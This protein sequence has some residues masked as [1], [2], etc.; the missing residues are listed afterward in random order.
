MRRLV[1]PLLFLLLA[2]Q[3]PLQ[4]L[5]QDT[6]P[7]A[8][9][10]QEAGQYF[11]IKSGYVPEDIKGVRQDL[12]A[13]LKEDKAV[14]IDVCGY[15]SLK[16]WDVHQQGRL[17]KL[18]KKHGPDGSGKMMIFWVNIDSCDLSVLRG[19]NPYLGM[20]DWTN[21]E[22]IP[23]PI[24]NSSTFHKAMDFRFIAVPRFYLVE[25]SG[26]CIDITQEILADD[27]EA[28]F[29]A[30]LARSVTRGKAPKALDI[31]GVKTLFPGEEGFFIP[32][33]RTVDP[34]KKPVWSVEGAEAKGDEMARITWSKPG[35]YKVTATVENASGKDA[36]SITVRVLE[37]ADKVSTLSPFPVN[38]TFDNSEIPKGWRIYDQDGDGLCWLPITKD[39]KGRIG[40]QTN[41]G[42]NGT[43][44]ALVSYTYYMEKFDWEYDD[45]YGYV[46]S[47]EDWL[48]SPAITI[49]SNATKSALKYLE[50]YFY[51]AENANK[52]DGYRL[53]LS[54]TG[55]APEDFTTVL[56]DIP[57][58]EK[59]T[60]TNKFL[61]QTI[62][63]TPYRGKTI[64]VAFVHPNKY[65]YKEAGS[66]VII[67]EITIES[68]GTAAPTAKVH[69]VKGGARG[70]GSSWEKASGDLQAAIDVAISGD[71]I[72]V[73]AGT[74]HPTRLIDPKR[75]RSFAFLL[76]DGISLYGGFEGTEKSPEERALKTVEAPIG[77]L[78]EHQTILSGKLDNKEETWTRAMDE[79]SSYRYTW[80]VEGNADNANHILYLK[81]TEKATEGIVIDGF[82]LTG[83]NANQWQVYAGG[84][85]LYAKGKLRLSRSIITR[86]ASR[87]PV[88]GKSFKGGAIALLGDSE[89][90]IVENC[91][92]ESNL[93]VAPNEPA[94]GGSLYLEGGVVRNCIFRGSVAHDEGGAAT[95]V[96]ARA[97]SCF[98]YDC[99][100]G[101]GGSIS[102]TNSIVEK[103]RFYASR[104]LKGGAIH[105]K[106]GLVHHSVAAGCYADAPEFGDT[107]GGQGGGFFLLA[108]AKA[109]GCL[110]YNSTAFT[111]GGVRLEDGE[112][113]LSTVQNCTARMGEGDAN[114]SSKE[115]TKVVNTIFAHEAAEKDFAAP[116][117]FKGFKDAAE[118][119]I[120]GL[121]TADWS[122]KAGSSYIA[123]G[124][125]PYGYEEAT[126][127]FGTPR[128]RGGKIDQG[129]VALKGVIEPS[130]ANITLTFTSIEK[131]VTI[132]TGGPAGTSFQLDK[133]DGILESYDGAK[134]IT[135][136][137]IA[138]TIKIYGNDIAILKVIK[139][140]L[141]AVDFGE[142]PKLY[143][144]QLGGNALKAISLSKLPA[145]KGLYLEQNQIAGILDLSAQTF[146]NV[147]SIYEN[148][149]SGKL[150]LSRF[151][152]LTKVEC[153][154]NALTELLL[155]STDKFV[156]L[157]C[158]ENQLKTLDLKG[159][160]ALEELNC[161][162]NALT[163]LDL[164]KNAKLVKLYCPENKLT[165]LV[166]S[167]NPEIKTFTAFNNKIANID[168]SANKKM[169]GLYIQ[170]NELK[171]IDLTPCT[172]LSYANVSN[173]HLTSLSLAGL[174]SLLM[175][176]AENNQLSALSLSDN[177]LINTLHLG[178]NNLTLL[179]VSK[180]TGLSWLI[181]SENKLAELDLACNPSIVWLECA[182]NTLTKL[183]LTKQ[184]SLQKLLVNHNK[185]TELDLAGKDNL[186][187]VRVENN[188]LTLE[189]LQKM[190]ID[191]PDVSAVK[192]HDNN[193]EWA[194]K[195]DISNNPGTKATDITP[196]QG[197][198]WEVTNKTA[199]L[200]PERGLPI[201]YYSTNTKSIVI[202]KDA[203][204]LVVYDALGGKVFEIS[205]PEREVSM[206]M[207]PAG[208]Y[209]ARVKVA[210]GQI[211]SVLFVKE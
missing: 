99:Y 143:S 61:E 191:L 5:A 159:L 77:S 24:I 125:I 39:L 185:L 131:E 102:A 206:A 116:T 108:G 76:K 161:G 4:L 195:L 8:S 86:N 148:K 72:W 62:D 149:I 122:L 110:V 41:E 141:E 43:T 80:K 169:E 30:Q 166:T 69:Y 97:D 59:Q 118:E 101:L 153:F 27:Y 204:H 164:S 135:F 200:S 85:A 113:I 26:W 109:I 29:E 91:L 112:L 36:K 132:G 51:K 211:E 201:C 127:L 182:K 123:S 73:A 23:Y 93:A 128:L 81:G 63:L 46:V 18:Y 14:L 22:S 42:L 202:T 70:D 90:T 181:C 130:T 198:G 193:R 178:K 170:N 189:A 16:G 162:G 96:N 13:Y 40:I 75:K 1:T 117:T 120:A 129:A 52:P 179:D 33:V 64:R 171:N 194:K 136:K 165:A 2:L 88:E 188:L 175:L 111:G 3:L 98:F 155:P 126:D 106:G 199:V 50:G 196:A 187:G 158:D 133:G 57:S 32:I 114:I 152:A 140:E 192:I 105:S 186:Q 173:N 67:D 137:P 107:S 87:N 19:E 89:E 205:A 121:K 115:G 134:N 6:L 60:E 183:D 176:S 84:S 157:D 66:G 177:P 139:Q 82:T 147:V 156:Q 150:D 208:S 55:V 138:K 100:A 172:K 9:I 25:P 154:K 74:Y 31:A 21:G 12:Q 53:L 167:A 95:L 174:A 92:F 145:L 160:T 146:I 184:K 68:D 151:T 7:G 58:L 11:R 28:K 20:G 210:I 79:G 163:E 207:L 78:L 65:S 15:W 48:I 203:V 142:N 17:E 54:E 83:G 94:T 124:V 180:Q 209:V 47:P 104:S 38:Y 35:E 190:V 45:P 37:E 197:K 34:L 103:C 168:L 56:L 144:L 44:D 119:T 71:Q 49:P 10:Q